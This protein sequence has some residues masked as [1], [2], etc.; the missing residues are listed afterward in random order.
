M[1]S[2]LLV[3]TGS[4][5]IIYSSNVITGNAQLMSLTNLPIVNINANNVNVATNASAAILDAETNALANLADSV[6]ARPVSAKFQ[7][8]R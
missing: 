4:N 3:Y 7:T 2:A 1:R 6:I 5:N 8:G